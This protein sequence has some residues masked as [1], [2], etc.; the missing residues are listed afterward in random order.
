ME[1]WSRP[2]RILLL[3][4]DLMWQDLIISLANEYGISD[5]LAVNSISRF[6]SAF[7]VGEFRAVLLD[8]QVIDGEAIRKERLPQYIHSQDETVRIGLISGWGIINELDKSNLPRTEFLGK[9]PSR[10]KEFLY[11][12]TSFADLVRKNLGPKK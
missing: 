5:V 4:D 12:I 7:K 1:I 9:E 2:A 6:R 8:N 10:I 3:E 11:G